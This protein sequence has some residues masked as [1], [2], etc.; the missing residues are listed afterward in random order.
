MDIERLARVLDRLGGGR[1]A[2]LRVPAEAR[3][4]AP[5]RRAFTRVAWLLGLLVLIGAGAVGEAL[6]LVLTGDRISG[7]VWW[8]LVVVFL[9]ATTLFYFRWRARRGW[10]WAYSRLRLF[11]IVFPVVAVT[12]CLIPGLYPAWMVIE[13]IAFSAVLLVIFWTLTRAPVMT[14]Y[15]RPR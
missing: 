13:Q 10:W 5:V 9:I 1:Q 11:S 2:S 14:A 6:D 4:E 3:E 8:R 12:T 7:F 15:R